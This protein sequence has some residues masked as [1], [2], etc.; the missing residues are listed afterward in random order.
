MSRFSLL[1]MARQEP[2]PVGLIGMVFIC[3]FIGYCV[4]ADGAVVSLPSVKSFL[5]L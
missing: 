2:G 3:P 5:I 1:P 4:E